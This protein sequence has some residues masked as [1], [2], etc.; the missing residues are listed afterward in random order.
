MTV[1]LKG[2]LS[3][4]FDCIATYTCKVHYILV[5]CFSVDITHLK[6]TM[7]NSLS[8]LIKSSYDKSMTAFYNNKGSLRQGNINHQIFQF[9]QNR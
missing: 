3:E 5:C 2:F 9:Y 6:F 7:Q 8:D 1:I 4:L